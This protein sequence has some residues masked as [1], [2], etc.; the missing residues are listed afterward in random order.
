MYN[1]CDICIICI[2]YVQYLSNTYIEYTHIRTYTYTYVYT[3]LCYIHIIITFNYFQLH[4]LWTK[5]FCVLNM[6]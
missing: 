5:C 6:P 2:I 1:T 3:Q 4:G